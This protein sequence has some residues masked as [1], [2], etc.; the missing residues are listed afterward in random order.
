MLPLTSNSNATLTPPM[1]LAEVGDRARLAAVGHFE[2]AHRQILNEPAFLI[3][4]DGGHPDQIDARLEMLRSG[5][6]AP[7]ASGR[8]PRG[9]RR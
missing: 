2:I 1:I 9:L 7:L 4:D 6:P 5:A 3:A 8:V